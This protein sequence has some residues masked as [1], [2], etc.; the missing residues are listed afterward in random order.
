MYSNSRCGR[1]QRFEVTARPNGAVIYLDAHRLAA[2]HLAL[3]LQANR[4]KLPHG[5]AWPEALVISG[6]LAPWANELLE[7]MAE[8]VI[9]QTSDELN[10]ALALDWHQIPPDEE[11]GWRHTPIGQLVY[12][13]KYQA[14]QLT[15]PEVEARQRR[16]A[17][18]MAAVIRRHALYR[19]ASAIV[20]VPPSILRNRG[21]AVQLA[22]FVASECGL[23]L[24][25]TTGVTPIRPQRKAGSNV[26]LSDEFI[27][28]PTFVRDQSVIVIDDL[29]KQGETMRGVAL[30]ARRA[31][32]RA[33]LGLA[34][35]RTVSNW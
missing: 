33:V 12:E 17:E 32:A 23:P 1:V 11:H 27:V 24:V 5:H 7:L 28:D 34:A 16:I 19:Q 14:W 8:V 2:E 13:S 18:L 3:V 4:V 9:M 20:T 15:P 21:Y 31:E 26:D 6:R 22:E 25:R 30:A 35:T 29:F 10:V